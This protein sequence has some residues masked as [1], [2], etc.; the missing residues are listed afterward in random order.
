MQE[1]TAEK[2]GVEPDLVGVASTGI[3][4]E[5]LPM[6][7]L[8]NGLSK[9]VVNGNADDF[10]KAILTTDTATKTIAVTET[11]GRDVVTMAGVAKGSGMIHPNMAT[12]LGFVTCDANISSDTLQLAL[13]QN[14]EKTFNQITVDGDTSTND[15]VLVMSNGCTLN[16]EILPDTPEFDKFSKMLNFVM[17]ELA[18]KIAKDGEG[19]NKLIQVDVVNAPNALDARMMAKSV[20]GSSLVKTAIFGEDPNWGRILAAV[21]YAGVDVPVDNVDI[22]LG[23]LP[24]MLAS[25]PVSFDDEEMKDIM[26]DDEVTITVDLHAGHEKGTAWGC[27]LSYGYV[28]INALYHT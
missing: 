5:L 10:A 11:F 15:M 27:D 14:V 20:V 23:G 1:W 25:S 7:T 19:A 8:K 3:I 2:L 17:Q 16:E 28:K 22:M 26:H 18:K 21:G 12:M 13:S 9:L 4:G 6:D 24:V